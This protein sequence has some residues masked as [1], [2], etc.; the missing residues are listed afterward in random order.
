MLELRHAQA[1]GFKNTKRGDRGQED[2][3]GDGL[4]DGAGEK[5]RGQPAVR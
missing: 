2:G 5:G 4:K 1:R 3:K